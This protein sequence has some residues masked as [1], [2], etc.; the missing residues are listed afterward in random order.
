MCE[1]VS[2]EWRRTNPDL[3][4]YVPKTPGGADN[5]NQHFNVVATPSGA[6][7]ATWTC[8]SRESDPN[9]RVVFSRSTDRGKTWIEPQIIDGPKP[10]D[11]PGTGLASWQF[12]IVGPRRIWCFYNKNIGIDDARTADTGVLRCRYSDDDG[13]TW[14]ARSYDYMIEPNAISHPDPKIPPT[15]IVYQNPTVTPEGAVLAGFTRWA[16]NAVD[17]DI[18]MFERASEICFLRFENILTEPDPQ[19]L[20]VTTWPKTPH[21]L[22]VPNP[23]RP[24]INT[25]QEPTNPSLS[26]GRL[27]CPMRTLRGRI[28]FALSEDDGRSWDQPR[29]LRYQPGGAEILHPMAPC[30]LYKLK[31]GRFLLIF[32]NNDG[33]GHGGRGPT[34]SINVRNPAYITIGREIPGDK[35]QPIRFGPPKL[36]AS[37]DWTP[38][39]GADT[40]TQ[41]ATYTS[42]VEDR[43]ERILFYP[44]RK[45]FLLGRY[46]TDEWLADCD[47]G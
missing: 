19:K 23:M 25:A 37:T 24:G 28:Y 21:G 7:L 42:L 4:I 39:P 11:P 33:S 3:I 1:H 43:G 15:W 26:D 5:C 34:D 36:F 22:S 18:G 40:G 32:Y 16:S 41:V 10:D 2:K 46:L 29:I 13:V 12:L 38:V 47:P 9:Q 20:I 14:S 45:H 35:D 6:F 27:I 30:P 17:P 31:D 8:A 44:D